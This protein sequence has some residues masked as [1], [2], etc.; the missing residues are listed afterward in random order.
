[1]NDILIF[2][3]F[4]PRLRVKELLDGG[5]CLVPFGDALELIKGAEFSI[6]NLEMPATESDKTIS[7]TGPNLKGNRNIVSA[8]KKAGFGLATLANNHMMDYGK[9]G[10]YDT[11]KACEEEGLQIVGAGKSLKEARTIATVIV[12]DKKIAIINVCENEWSTTQGNYPGC[13]PLDL[14][15]LDEDIAKARAS[16]DFVIVIIHGGH[17]CYELPSPRMVKQYRWLCDKGADA[18]I[19]HHTHCFSG[20][21]LYNGKP[22]VYSLGNFIF[23]SDYRG[24]IWNIGA[25]AVLNI[26]QDDKLELG[27]IPFS[28]CD[29]EPSVKL[30]KDK[31]LQDWQLMATEKSQ[32]ISD[33][34]YIAIEF[35]KFS[36]RLGKSF[37][38]SL[39]PFRSRITDGLRSRG[40]LPNVLTKKQKT[41][42]LNIVRDEAHRDVL[43]KTLTQEYENYKRK[44]L[45]SS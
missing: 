10:L 13:N 44:N 19:G 1:M 31:E 33:A 22:I 23:D 17:E 34:A 26:N 15:N 27:L 38:N 32:K 8:L 41:L 30:L 24:N 5:N 14:I 11:L 35:E 6:V 21:E 18:V 7:K 28:Q 3:D 29:A 36:S 20:H 42:L 25:A 37:L 9:D 43:I 45:A 40:L 12:K 4:A 39:E 2:G 16:H